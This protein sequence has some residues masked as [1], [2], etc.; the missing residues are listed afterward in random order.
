MNDFT[1]DN[2]GRSVAGFAFVLV[3][4]LVFVRDSLSKLSRSFAA[5]VC[6]VNV[7]RRRCRSRRAL[8][9]CYTVVSRL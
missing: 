1:I 3:L 4:V 2:A 5:S 6:K 9:R 8:R 7:S